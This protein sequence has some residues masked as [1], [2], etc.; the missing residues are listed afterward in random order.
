MTT[1]DLLRR[2]VAEIETA[3]EILYLPPESGNRETLDTMET[4]YTNAAWAALGAQERAVFRPR[5]PGAMR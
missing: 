3:F 4:H 2:D 1:L 5:T